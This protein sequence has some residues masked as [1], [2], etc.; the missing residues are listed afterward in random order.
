MYLSLDPGDERTGWARFD[1]D[2][3][4]TGHGIIRG[5]EAVYE[6]LA[7]ETI[8]SDEKKV[9]LIICEDYKLFDFAAKAQSWSKLS[10][11]RLIGAIDLWCWQQQIKLV[12]DPAINLGMG[13]MY[14]GMKKPKG[15]CPDD[16]SA[17]FHGV[18]VLQQ[19]GIRRAQQLTK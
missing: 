14:A 10:T 13:A 16:L 6:L 4:N 19:Q 17:Y 11:V 15:H 8:K 1:K 18:Y 7:E 12:L 9:K 2:G 3:Q 5:K